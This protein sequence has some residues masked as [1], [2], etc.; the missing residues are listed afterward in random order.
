MIHAGAI[1]IPLRREELLL[2]LQVTH[3]AHELVL[4]R[5][6][7]RQLAWE[8]GISVLP[9]RGDGRA[10]RWLR[11]HPIW[12]PDEARHPACLFSGM[13]NCGHWVDNS[14]TW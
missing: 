12:H 1:I 4:L 9:N 10:Y 3:A 2:L 13:R 7:L 11:G 5:P 6:A 14:G 8:E